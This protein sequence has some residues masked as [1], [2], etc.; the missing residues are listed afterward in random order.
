MKHNVLPFS[1]SLEATQ[2][3]LEQL[4]RRLAKLE[5]AHNANGA[6]M[7]EAR[8][9]LNLQDMAIKRLRERRGAKANDKPKQ[10]ASMSMKSAGEGL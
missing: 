8:I 2:F 10:E 4:T 9:Q 6:E 1:A 5:R 3:A 7:K